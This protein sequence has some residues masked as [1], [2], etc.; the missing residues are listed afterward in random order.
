MILGGIE[1]FGNNKTNGD[2]LEMG[3]LETK[4]ISS[5]KKHSSIKQE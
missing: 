3:N 1:I 2:N 5:S 4:I